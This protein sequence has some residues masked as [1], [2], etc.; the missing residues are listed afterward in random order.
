MEFNMDSW[1]IDVDQPTLP[2]GMTMTPAR[3]GD[4]M[5]PSEMWR[6]GT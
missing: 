3:A 4:Q 1:R 2:S 5:S 6:D